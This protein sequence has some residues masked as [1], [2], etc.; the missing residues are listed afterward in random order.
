M[1]M[2]DDPLVHLDEVFHKAV[3]EVTEEGTEAAAASVGIIMTRSMPMPP[4]KLVFDRPFVMIILHVPT[5]TPLFLAR[6]DDP[7]LMF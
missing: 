2:S 5:K 3:M 1:E 6:V 7:E 4:E